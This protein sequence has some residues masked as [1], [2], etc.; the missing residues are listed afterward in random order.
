MEINVEEQKKLAFCQCKR[1]GN[2]PF[3]DGTHNKL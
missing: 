3:C 2:A 1:T